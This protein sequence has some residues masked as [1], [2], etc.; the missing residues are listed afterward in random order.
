MHREGREPCVDLVDPLIV[1]FI[2]VE[3]TREIEAMSP[4]LANAIADWIREAAA[5]QD[6]RR[7][8]RLANLAAP[9]QAPG[10]G[11]ALRDLLDA[12]IAELNNEDMVDL[13]GE[14][15]AT[16]AASS[17]FRLVTRSITADAPA[18]WLCQKS[19]LSLSEFG[20]EEANEY[21]RVL[22][23]STWPAPIRWHSAVALGIE[24]SL[25][26]EEGQM[27]G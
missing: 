12:D 7:V 10:L 21:L 24:D 1:G 8:E 22:T 25:G 9:L 14:I 15:R 2:T 4:G 19:I 18:Y 16:G 27:L 26:F 3:R 5:V 6:W 17:I 20:T 13:L 11:D 23:T